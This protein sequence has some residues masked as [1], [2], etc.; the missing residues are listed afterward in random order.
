M[1]DKVWP[2]GP[3]NR[4]DQTNKEMD[5]QETARLTNKYELRVLLLYE[6]PAYQLNNTEWTKRSFTLLQWSDV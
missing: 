6:T 2:V 1:S 5:E 3:R 4:G